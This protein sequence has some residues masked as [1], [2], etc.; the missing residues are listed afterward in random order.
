MKWT[1]N[2][3]LDDWLL[4][5]KKF[6]APRAQ[7]AHLGSKWVYWAQKSSL[8]FI[9][10]HSLQIVGHTGTQ[11]SSPQAHQGSLGSGLKVSGSL[12]LKLFHS[13][14]GPQNF[15]SSLGFKSAHR[16]LTKIVVFQNQN[17]LKMP[18]LLKKLI[19]VQ[20]KV[21]AHLGKTL[22]RLW[23]IT[24][25]GPKLWENVMFG[26]FQIGE[27]KLDFFPTLCL[28]Y[29]FLLK[30]QKKKMFKNIFSDTLAP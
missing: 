29:R 23:K 8:G 5:T 21:V 7:K 4:C 2:D 9:G 27:K 1:F 22:Y 6:W 12:W 24:L 20:K 11:K 13:K 14:I 3:V 10:T 19:D 16:C 26:N 18:Q 30:T 28:F 15:W 17:E 25:K